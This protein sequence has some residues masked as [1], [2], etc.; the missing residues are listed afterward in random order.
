LEKKK[1]PDRAKRRRRNRK[2]R[3][4]N[5]L[6]ITL[7]SFCP[8]QMNKKA[9]APK[10]DVTP[11]KM[12][13]RVKRRRRRRSKIRNAEHSQEGKREGRSIKCMQRKRRT[14]KNEADKLRRSEYRLMSKRRRR[15]FLQG[16]EGQ[17]QSRGGKRL[18]RKRGRAEAGLDR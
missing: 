12:P 14:R 3:N 5:R 16:S 17:C 10:S 9:R 7:E 18:K 4:M 15:I 2:K 11:T 6:I 13:E 8:A 1:G